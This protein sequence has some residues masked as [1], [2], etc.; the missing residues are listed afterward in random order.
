MLAKYS[1]VCHRCG[2]KGHMARE[3]SSVAFK[4][5][6]CGEDHHQS[7]CPKNTGTLENMMKRKTYETSEF[8]K[9]K[10][11]AEVAEKTR[12]LERV[13][14]SGGAGGPGVGGASTGREKED[15]VLCKPAGIVVVKKKKKKPNPALARL[16]VTS[17][18]GGGG[19]KP[20]PSTETDD[21][22]PDEKKPEKA[23]A[24]EAKRDDDDDGGG[25]GGLLG[26]LLGD[27]G[28]DSD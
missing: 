8:A 18:G 23:E 12:R 19:E 15:A 7:E 17:K 22:D 28:S 20:P 1:E 21:A 16:K 13:I 6:I 11:A 4:C 9:Q 24:T 26:G 3:C 2:N 5:R 25:D 14:A 10:L 27:Y